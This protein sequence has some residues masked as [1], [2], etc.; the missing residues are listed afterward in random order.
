MF[1]GPNQADS[2]EDKSLKFSGY[3]NP[4]RQSIT[5]CYTD[6][7]LPL[8]NLSQRVVRTKTG[9]Q[10]SLAAIQGLFLASQHKQRLIV[11]AQC[12]PKQFHSCE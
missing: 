7:T 4:R 5:D 2:T 6:L 3:S 12:A 11:V 10:D 9:F 1:V 8:S